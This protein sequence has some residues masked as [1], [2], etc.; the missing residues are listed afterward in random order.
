MLNFSSFRIKKLIILTL[1][2]IKIED[3]YR[4]ILIKEPKK[5]KGQAESQTDGLH[6]Y[7]VKNKDNKPV[8]IIDSQGFGDTR[9]KEY[10]ELIFEKYFYI[11]I[12]YYI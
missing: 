6:L 1:N 5:P 4:Y 7:Y 9:G 8:I 3:N 2:F 10:D 12:D 11:N